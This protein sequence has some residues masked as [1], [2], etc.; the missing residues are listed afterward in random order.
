MPVGPV[1]RPNI[2]ITPAASSSSSTRS[3]PPLDKKP[4]AAAVDALAASLAPQNVEAPDGKGILSAIGDSML[5]RAMLGAA[6]AMAV[7]SPMT[8]PIVEAHA[9][10]PQR[11]APDARTTLSFY[12]ARTESALKAQLDKGTG[13]ATLDDAVA[14]TSAITKGHIRTDRGLALLTQAMKTRGVTGEATAHLTGFFSARAATLAKPLAEHTSAVAL[15]MLGVLATNNARFDDVR[16]GAVGD[17]YFAASAAAIVARD[18]AFPNRIIAERV[19][20]DGDR[21]YEVTMSQ[22]LLNLPQGSYTVAVQDDVWGQDGRALYGQNTSGHWFQVLEQAAAKLDGSFGKLESGFGFEAMAK[23]TG[24]TAGYA[25]HFAGSDRTEVFNSLKQ[26]FDAGNAMT[27][28]AHAFPDATF[29]AKHQGVFAD[30]HEYAIIDVRGTTAQDAE[31]ELY[32]PWGHVLTV[33]VDE[34]ARNFLGFSYLDLTQE[35]VPVKLMPD[36]PA[37]VRREDGNL[38]VDVKRPV[39][40]GNKDP[41]V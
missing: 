20:L 17:C 41:T 16:Q 34:F 22:N 2:A 8:R 15:P 14:V 33:S 11:L 21:F 5:G 23:L 10:A 36:Q 9:A 29:V 6:G 32:N 28:G 3:G 27:T 39:A 30:L 19:S 13:L 35:K 40:M 38:V 31:I 26:H 1:Q 37:I 24:L 4:I 7:L 25:F 12:E 18:P